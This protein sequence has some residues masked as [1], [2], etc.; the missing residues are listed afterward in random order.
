MA[1]APRDENKVPTLLAVSS[2]DGVTPVVVYADPTTHRLLVDL[3]GGA[4]TFLALS[5]TPSTFVGQA[6]KIPVVNVGETALEFSTAGAGDVVGPASSTDNSIV[7]FNSTTGKLIQSSGVTVSDN[8]AMAITIADSINEVG[9]AI[10]PN[11]VTNKPLGLQVGAD[12]SKVTTETLVQFNDATNG[13]YS[14]WSFNVPGNGY[15]A[16][17]LQSTGG[18]LAA[19]TASN[20]GQRS[21]ITTLAYNSI[22]S[23]ETITEIVSNLK[24]GTSGSVDSSVVIK[25]SNAGVFDEMLQIGEENGIII[26]GIAVGN[27]FGTAI[28]TTNGANDLVLQTGNATT[29][30]ITITNGANGAINLVPDGTGEVQVAG[31]KI[32]DETDTASTTQAGIVELATDAEFTTKTDETRYVNAK[33]VGSVTQTLTNKTLVDAKIQTTT[34]AQTGTT[35]TLV[36]TDASKWVTMSNAAA[37]TLTVPPNSSVAF[38]VGTRLMV[39]QKGAGATTIAAGAGVTINAPSTV[40]LAIGEQYESRGLL[41]TATDTWELI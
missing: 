3:A 13:N 34:N 39:Q 33:Q 35:Y 6:G 31:Q 11:D 25:V 29:S 8:D 32:I 4:S 17:N 36:L 10:Y 12:A 7:R 24:D 28:V 9:L 23:Q 40:T 26:N 27:P 18:T 15:P 16:L 21:S 2:V 1:D 30:S 22:P 20:T 14:D 19:P 5:D 41:K 38:A 37:N